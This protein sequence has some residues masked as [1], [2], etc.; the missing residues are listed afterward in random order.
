MDTE[1]EL[2]DKQTECFEKNRLPESK[3]FK[4]MKNLASNNISSKTKRD[5]TMTRLI[6]SVHNH[7]FKIIEKQ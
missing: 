1:T 3:F 7:T 2:I 4:E 6:I 5:R